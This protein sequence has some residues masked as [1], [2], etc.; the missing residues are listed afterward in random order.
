MNKR[1]SFA[2]I[3]AFAV[4]P[5][6]VLGAPSEELEEV[7]V[8]GVTPLSG[9]GGLA[10]EKIPYQVQSISSDDLQRSQA[11]D[12]SE[13][14]RRRLPG[15]TANDAQSNKRQPDILFHGFTASPL[16]G[17]PQGLSVYLN[18]VRFNEPFGDT[19]NWDLISGAATKSIS[20]SSGANPVYGLNTLGGAIVVNT[21]TGFSSPGVNAAASF[22]SFS[23][24]D[25]ELSAGGS[26]GNL[27]YFIGTEYFSENGWRDAS[28]SEVRNLFINIGHESDSSEI[29]LN[30]NVANNEL[31]GNGPAP[32]DLLHSQGR[33]RIF[34]SPDITNN[35][36]RM[37]D[38]QFAHTFNDDIQIAGSAFQRKNNVDSFNGDGSE[39][40]ACQ[41]FA[42]ELLEDGAAS[43]MGLTAQQAVNMLSFSGGA[44]EHLCATEG[45]DDQ[46]GTTGD[47]VFNSIQNF[48][49]AI[50]AE[51]IEDQ[52]G[53]FV[54]EDEGN[55]QERNA[56]N[57]T[58]G[59]LQDSYGGSLQYIY[60]ADIFARENQLITGIDY[61][62]G[63]V[64]FTS[65][66]EVARLDSNRGTVA[67]GLYVPEEGV[68]L[69]VKTSTISA[70][71]TDTISLTDSLHLT[72]SGRYNH[73][74]IKLLDQGGRRGRTG[75]QQD[76]NGNHS[77]TRFNPAIG[78]SH[79]TAAGTKLF[80]SYS[81][82][83][84]TPSPIELACARPDAPC[85]LPNAFLA[86]P[87]LE[88]VV[89]RS[90]D[91][92]ANGNK[93]GIDWQLA[94]YASQNEEDILFQTTGGISSNEGYFSNVGDTRRLGF[95]L[96]LGGSINDYF[97]WNIAYGFIHATYEDS[98]LISSPNHVAASD[99][100]NGEFTVAKGNRITGI[101]QHSL[102][103]QLTAYPDP[104]NSVTLEMIAT[105]NRHL[106]GDEANIDRKIGGFV[107]FNLIL[108]HNL[109]DS[110]TL[111][112]YIE[113]I[114]DNEYQTFGLY[115]E[116]D[117]VGIPGSDNYSSRFVGPGAP[118]AYY[119]SLA[120]AF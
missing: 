94:M 97:D 105:S 8:I 24:Q 102:K 43:I 104:N 7:T 120:F 89:T 60:S 20:I 84:R 71:F 38:L 87:P 64:E 17:L 19:V 5:C 62:S 39:F 74:N 4:M 55:G 69:N 115:G 117:E 109:N 34:T 57:N 108:S 112:A 9:A 28:S 113:N 73:S 6:T 111:T 95:D 22:G 10:D 103:S 23:S 40:E 25:V 48:V 91:F 92:G 44:G 72:L 100:N 63:D 16:L 50:V 58:S 81:E 68:A 51:R 88:Q 45:V 32:E 90:V 56:I 2:T 118:R 27:G 66:V 47:D 31:I 11:V 77:F 93:L 114:L 59:R 85:S 15:I 42:T 80:A 49:S 61:Y 86:D 75:A 106:R 35:N 76:L 65:E 46:S 18:G 82:A 3:F 30:L 21:H 107:L 83:S 13:Y 96:L 67:T 98:F 99:S 119:L 110:I 78:V 79:L 53:D 26:N 12:F 37:L 116:A 41:G 52:N 29:N 36:F 14:A 101:P 70:F 1:A 33:S 54:D